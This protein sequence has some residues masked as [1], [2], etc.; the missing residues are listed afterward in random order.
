MAE[1]VARK[2]RPQEQTVFR[3]LRTQ[4]KRAWKHKLTQI[5]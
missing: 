5:T 4:P 3:D 2:K 1:L